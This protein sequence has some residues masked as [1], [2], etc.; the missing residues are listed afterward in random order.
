MKTLV[1]GAAG[2][3]GSHLSESLLA[4]GFDVI[5][6]DS[7]CTNYDIRFKRENLAAFEKKSGFSLV[8]SDLNDL[9]LGAILEGVDYVFHL[10][11]QAG[12]RDSWRSQFDSYVDANIRATQRLCEAARDKSVRRFV[13]ASS[14]SVYGETQELPM[15][16][17]HPTCPVSP[18]GVTKLS[19]EALCLLYRSNFG[20]PVV[21]LRFFTVFGPR[22]RPDMAFHRF[23]RAGLHEQPVAV[24]GNGLQ[25][26]DF[27]FVSDI[28]EACTLAMD[29][30][31]EE[32]VFNVGGGTRIALNTALDIIS[33][34]LPAG[35]DVRY[36]DRAKGDVSHTYADISL[37]RG[38]LGYA[39]KTTVEE[40]LALEA[41][42]LQSTLKRM[43]GD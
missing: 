42:W 37:A 18:Y 32:S 4:K 17:T 2:F 39:P 11:A 30:D 14:S 36:E 40:G 16:E 15:S 7:L 35:L 1:T 25:T 29:Y 20:L 12:V 19:G 27:T 10:A 8:E 34:I 5:G 31:G 38:E 3:I 28:V 33:G 23:I 6:V 21:A 26:R 22:Q 9:D 41:E 13:Y 43:I 24:F